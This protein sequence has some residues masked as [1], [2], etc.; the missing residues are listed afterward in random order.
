MMLIGQGK[1]GPVAGCQELF[2]LL[3]QS[4]VH[5]WPNGVLNVLTGQIVSRCDLRLSGR[6]LIS[7]FLN[8]VIAVKPELYSCLGAQDIVQARVQS[9]IAACE[10]GIAAFVMASAFSLVISP[11]HR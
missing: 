3:R 2:V 9:L 7:L 6:L 5:Y 8:D 11:C 10:S 4:H 1:A